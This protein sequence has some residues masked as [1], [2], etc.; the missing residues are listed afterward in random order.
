MKPYTHFT[1]EERI[2]LEELLN[3]GKSISEIAETLGRDRST[4]YREIKRNRNQQGRYNSWGAYTK[5]KDRRKVCVRKLRIQ[6][7][8]EL[9]QFIAEHL[10]KYWSPEMIARRWNAAH[11]DDHISFDG[12]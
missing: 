7:G 5:A 4:I 6:A 9:H 10:R 11:T 3:F 1:T 12:F 8:S 2:C